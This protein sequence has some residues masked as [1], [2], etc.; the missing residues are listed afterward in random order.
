MNA[1]LKAGADLEV[2]DLTLPMLKALWPQLCDLHRAHW[3]ETEAYRH[4]KF[5]PRYD[6]LQNYFERGVARAWG[7]FERAKL[8]GHITMYVSVSVHTGETIATEDAVYV[9]PA[10]RTGVGAR[11]I[12]RMIEDLRRE[13]IAEIWATTKP[14]TRVGRLLT[15]LGW[16]FVA[17]QYHIRLGAP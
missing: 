8:V 10:Y 17:E 3:D 13:G 2:M 1:Q 7:A 15:R 16:K 5:A 12:K 6:L 14:A 11:L 9:L 4:S